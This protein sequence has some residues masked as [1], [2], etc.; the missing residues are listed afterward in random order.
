MRIKKANLVHWN[1]LAVPTAS[2]A[3]LDAKRW[4]LARLTNTCKGWA[5]K[6][7]SQ[8]LC[9]TDSCCGL[10]LPQRGWCYSTGRM[11]VQ[12]IR[13][14]IIGG[15]SAWLKKSLQ[16]VPGNDDVFSILPVSESIK[17]AKLDLCLVF[18]VALQFIRL[19]PDFRSEIYNALWRLCLSDFN[20]TVQMT[21]GTE[22]NLRYSSL[23]T[24]YEQRIRNRIDN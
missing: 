5:T 7:R 12:S 13:K 3:T 22:V 10:A 18:S 14:S 4:S 1:D 2:G 19:Q 11:I 20:V 16:D 17:H 9:Q 23:P 21:K 6:M 15:D 24:R 8:C